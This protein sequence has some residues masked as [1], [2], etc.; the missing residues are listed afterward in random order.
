MRKILKFFTDPRTQETRDTDKLGNTQT[1]IVQGE[2]SIY[3]TRC[4]G[5]ISNVVAKS[6]IRAYKIN[7]NVPEEVTESQTMMLLNNPSPG[8]SLGDLLSAFTRNILTH[9]R[10]WSVYYEDLGVIFVLNPENVEYEL[11]NGIINKI[12]TGTKELNAEDIVYAQANG[13]EDPWS[14]NARTVKGSEK[15]KDLDVLYEI[16]NMTRVTAQSRLKNRA[17]VGGIYSLKSDMQIITEERRD[18]LEDKLVARHSG[19]ANAGKPFFTP[20]LDYEEVGTTPTADE[21]TK[22]IQTVKD[23]VLAYRGVPALMLGNTT[24][25]TNYSS[26]QALRSLHMSVVNPMVELFTQMINI[27]LVPRIEEGIYIDFQDA[28]PADIPELQRVLSE[29]YQNGAITH[30]EYRVP[31]GLNPIPDGNKLLDGTVIPETTGVKN[32]IDEI[33][34]SERMDRIKRI[35]LAQDKVKHDV[36]QIKDIA[37]GENDNT[38]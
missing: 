24:V 37:L 19:A 1:S 10:Y 25:A 33:Q 9:N 11:K 7:K 6:Q 8:K 27:Q 29:M 34:S 20:E 35:Q 26:A 31:L 30:N 12:K 36:K 18:E 32:V 2:G 23:E 17:A 38:D 15:F 14:A 13:T 4:I 21:Y 28:T 3:D 16:E 5:I 22:Y